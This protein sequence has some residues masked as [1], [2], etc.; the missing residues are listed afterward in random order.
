MA[1]AP[2]LNTLYSKVASDPGLKNKVKFIAAAQ[3]QEVTAAQMWKKFHQIP[4]AIVP[5]ADR[6]LSTAM[7]F[8]PYPV[9]ML[10]NKSGKVLWVEVGE[11]QQA[12]ISKAFNGIKSAVK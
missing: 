9:T 7:N 5:D 4:F 6:K 8:G 10:V 11:M 2:V 1:Q 12:D 3:G